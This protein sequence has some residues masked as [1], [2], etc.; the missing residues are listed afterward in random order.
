MHSLKPKARA[1]GD[2]REDLNVINPTPVK[3]RRQAFDSFF[4][5]MAATIDYR[6]KIRRRDKTKR[7]IHTK[8]SFRKSVQQSKTNDF[9]LSNERPD[10]FYFFCLAVTILT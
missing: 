4:F 5:S 7:S 6:K 1:S 2:N 3:K 8:K 10:L 9:T